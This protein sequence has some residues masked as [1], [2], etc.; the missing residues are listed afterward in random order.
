[1]KA[2]SVLSSAKAVMLSEL[3]GMLKQ[4]KCTECECSCCKAFTCQQVPIKVFLWSRWLSLVVVMGAEQSTAAPAA[5]GSDGAQQASPKPGADEAADTAN[6]HPLDLPRALVIVGPSGVGK[7]TLIQ[8]LTEGQK[9]LFGFSVS[10]TTRQPR[11][12][13]KVKRDW[14]R[15][16]SSNAASMC[17]R[18]RS[19]HLAQLLRICSTESITIL[20]QRSSLQRRSQKVVS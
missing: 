13:E 2:T 3:L 20:Q 12:G 6:G 19:E 18:S 15:R 17:S 7:G 4:A 11:A 16:L 10:H 14:C 1:M 5:A 8:K 9:E